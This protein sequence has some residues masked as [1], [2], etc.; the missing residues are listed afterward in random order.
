MNRVI[1]FS[2]YSLQGRLVVLLLLPVALIL[3]SAGG[4]GYYYAHQKILAQWNEAAILKLERAAHQIDMRLSK[5][6][7]LMSIF[8]NLGNGFDG[9][10]GQQ[11]L[12]RQLE[13]LDGIAAVDLLPAGESQTRSS[14]SGA[15]GHHMG[16]H[17]MMPFKRGVFSKITPPAHDAFS[18]DRTVSLI[19]DLLDDGNRKIAELHIKLRFDYLMKDVLNQGWWQGDMACLVDKEGNYLIH[20]GAMS[21]ERQKLGET[22]DPLEL[23]ILSRMRR[24]PQ[25]TVRGPG[26]T[27]E[28]VAG[29][30][31]LKQAPWV[32]VEF[33]PGRKILAPIVRFRNGF[34]A[35]ALVMAAGILWIVRRHVGSILDSIH[36]ISASA[37]QVA[38]GEYGDPIDIQST[39]EIGDLVDNYNAMVAGLRERDHIRNTFGCY[40]D[41]DF[42]KKLL[43][44][45]E[46]ARLGG[47]RREVVI[48]MS[49]IRGYTTLVEQMKPE[50]AIEILN[51]YFTHMIAVIQRHKGIIVDFV[52]DAILV[53]FEPLNET[54]AMASQRAVRCASQ[55]Q[56]AMM[57]TNEELRTKGHPNF[58]MGIGIHAGAVV[59][60][61]IGSKARAKYGIVGS[62][63]NLTQRVQDQAKGSEIVVTEAVFDQVKDKVEVLRAFQ[64][65][66]KGI[67]TSATLF[68]VSEKRKADESA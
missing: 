53:F 8:L 21:K 23:S 35:G 38:Q 16:M 62:A 36:K 61:N 5:P 50:T 3:F 44:R 28:M 54:F 22:G 27:P 57:R 13:T 12:L 55:M 1:K 34:I 48:L 39:D 59:V 4:I 60:G 10:A 26:H 52:G 25:A 49:D 14:A 19:S 56:Q 30:S 2:L 18:G 51:L 66:L 63:V 11:W 64:T 9:A 42:A 43:S 15:P 46:A 41:A 40:I 68:I 31:S 29:F 32:I 20:T 58:E 6:M 17:P 37:R 67:Q 7:E 33:A 65:R 45:P 24:Q 47:Q